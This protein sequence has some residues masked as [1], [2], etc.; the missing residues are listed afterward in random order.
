MHQY[1]CTG[2]TLPWFGPKK[3]LG[4]GWTPVTWQGWAITALFLACLLAVSYGPPFRYR[5]FAVLGLVAAYLAVVIAT[6][7][8]PGGSLS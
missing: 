1:R 2:G 3:T 5:L 6:G 8:K 7:T 4:W